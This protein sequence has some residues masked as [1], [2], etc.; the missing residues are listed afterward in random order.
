MTN[1]LGGGDGDQ[2]KTG[3]S[4]PILV[5]AVGEGAKVWTGEERV[6]DEC[7]ELVCKDLAL[8]RVLD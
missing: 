2:W 1:L 8:W 6:L 5:A 4:G 3:V 7:D